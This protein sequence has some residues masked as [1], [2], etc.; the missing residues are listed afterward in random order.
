MNEPTMLRFG[1]AEQPNRLRTY[2]EAVRHSPLPDSELSDNLGLYITPKLLSRF[3]F[4]S[5]LYQQI[6]PV[7]GVV[8]EFGC[9][10]GQNTCLFSSLRGIF[11]PFNRRR[12]VIGFDT[13]AGLCGVTDADGR[14][15]AESDYG[16]VPKY[17]GHLQQMLNLNEQE[18]PLPHLTKHAIITGDVSTT[19]PKY[20]DDNPQTVIA[21][22]YFD[23]DIY[24]P[25]K[26]ALEAIRPHLTRGSVLG[27]DELNDV[28]TPGETVA[29]REVFQLDRYRIQRLPHYGRSSYLTID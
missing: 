23:M 14:H 26:F 12:K 25:T 7:Q 17:V 29:L 3:L 4:M 2:S 15:V 21:L 20:L 18:S 27:F 28:T 8:V 10:W 1:D 13:F 5:H 9:R 19:L 24:G 22:A 6:L 11:E 16:V